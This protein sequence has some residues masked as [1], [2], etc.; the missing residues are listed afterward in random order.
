[1][2]TLGDIMGGGAGTASKSKAA[3]K[4]PAKP[5]LP[6]ERI[7]ELQAMRRAENAAIAKEEAAIR[8]AQAEERARA[9]AKSRRLPERVAVKQEPDDDD[10]EQ[11][12]APPAAQKLRLDSDLDLRAMAGGTRTAD[13]IEQR[14]QK[15]ASSK[16][17][18]SLPI[19]LLD[20]RVAQ[21][22][23]PHTLTALD[24]QTEGH[25]IGAMLLEKDTSLGS[26][27][28]DAVRREDELLARQQ[29]ED[30]EYDARGP[31]HV[32]D[33]PARH[34]VAAMAAG[35]VAGGG[36]V[37]TRR[38]RKKPKK[39]TEKDSRAK[40][41]QEERA[42]KDFLEP[43]IDEHRQRQDIISAE[44]KESMQTGAHKRRETLDPDDLP[45]DNLALYRA[46]DTPQAWFLTT[47]QAL[48]RS[49]DTIVH[50][51]PP[52]TV[53]HSFIAAME[54]NVLFFDAMIKHHVQTNEPIPKPTT[55]TWDFCQSL[56]RE[57]IPERGERPC[58][59]AAFGTCESVKQ[60]GFPCR[61]RMT[62]SEYLRFVEM[63]KTNPSKAAT[64]LPMIQRLCMCCALSYVTV[65]YLKRKFRLQHRDPD[66]EMPT[67][68]SAAYDL[69]TP[70]CDFD[71][72]VTTEGQ[73]YIWACV[74]VGDSEYCGVPGPVPQWD[75]S[76][77]VV[78]TTELETISI[79]DKRIQERTERLKRANTE[80]REREEGPRPWDASVWIA[81]HKRASQRGEDVTHVF[82]TPSRT[83]VPGR[84]QTAP[85]E[86]EVGMLRQRK[87]KKKT[88]RVLRQRDE[89]L[90]FRDGAMPV[91]VESDKSPRSTRTS[92]H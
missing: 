61:E 42:Q 6:P 80:R 32:F 70:L 43:T 30:G 39:L 83:P 12:I 29:T 1:M 38:R 13:A 45:Q 17:A 57:A 31:P 84:F 59:M 28:L 8:K 24:R 88:I 26:V 60:F 66:S 2:F 78:E 71:V 46:E 56:L 69:T 79:N 33:A 11:A 18:R 19:D 68:E 89:C 22:D 51:L 5:S 87:A 67:G 44:I 4:P 14:L 15:V 25:E 34:P 52:K 74:G 90:R 91:R 10:A 20:A 64:A 82:Q 48:D 75:P 55:L 40:Y 63:R 58:R 65:E 54:D 23:R 9:A 50:D 81:A 62:E 41:T 27:R 53:N 72:D 86:D 7:K 85:V 16:A 21:E 73:Y 3:N 47:M 35:Q 36:R 49:E 37:L 76:N 77:Y 92:C